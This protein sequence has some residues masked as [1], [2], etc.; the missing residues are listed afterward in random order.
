MKS[1]D[2]SDLN[3]I[4]LED[5][6][7]IILRMISDTEQALCHAPAGSLYIKK[8]SGG[9]T[10]YYHRLSGSNA[11]KIYLSPNQPEQRERIRLLAQKDYDQKLLRLLKKIRKEISFSG[12]TILS[13]NV[14]PPYRQI[15]AVYYALSR[16]R[17]AF[18]VPILPT[19][20]QYVSEWLNTSYEKKPFKPDDKSAFY[21]RKKERVRSKSELYIADQTDY[22]GIPRLYECPLY[23]GGKVLRPDFSILD[24]PYRRVKYLEHCGMMGHPEYDN[25][26]LWKIQ[27]YRDHGI[28]LGYDLILTFES[29]EQPFDTRAFHD[30]MRQHFPWAFAK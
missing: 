28:R 6:R 21:T 11:R 15:D 13:H 27:F 5:Y 3:V 2:T 8:K 18:V 4:P 9:R 10:E 26:L 29:S 30:L 14:Q 12:S 24:V 17:Q 22:L 25:Q 7:T 1:F 20:D 23:L 16:E 19:T